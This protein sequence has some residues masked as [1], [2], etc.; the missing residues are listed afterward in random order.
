MKNI[1]IIP[2]KGR[3][4]R[5]PGKNVKV[6]KG[7][8]MVC[9]AVKIA[10]ESRLFEKIIV[11]SE[12]E[13]VLDMVDFDDGIVKVKRDMSLSTDG[14]TVDEVVMSLKSRFSGFDNLCVLLPCTP[15]LESI[16]LVKSFGL[17][18][19]FSHRCV[20]CGQYVNHPAYA[21]NVDVGGMIYRERPDS[22]VRKNAAE[23]A[24]YDAGAFYWC[25]VSKFIVSAALVSGKALCYM[26]PRHKAVDI[27]TPEDLELV[28]YYW[29]KHHE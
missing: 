27:D 10:K 28:T 7:M 9:H 4:R 6:F 19:K 18:D 24:I 21:F 14:A 20:A 15:M 13:E 11:T 3:S 12:S 23:T 5:L 22:I 1:C 26:L 16:D 17:L 8:P 2:A 25:D 29:E